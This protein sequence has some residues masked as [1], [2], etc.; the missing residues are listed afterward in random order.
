MT[1]AVYRKGTGD[2]LLL[3]GV[4]VDDLIICGPNSQRIA[5]FKDQMKNTFSMSDLGLLSYYLGM[6]VKARERSNY[7]L[8]ESL[9]KEDS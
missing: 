1:H 4:Y 8:S 6:E 2:S 7:Y 5:E 3:I 9:C